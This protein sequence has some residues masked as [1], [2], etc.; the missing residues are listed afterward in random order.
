MFWKPRG[1]IGDP[2]IVIII[3]LVCFLLDFL[4]VINWS[5]DHQSNIGFIAFLVFGKEKQKSFVLQI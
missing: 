2:T 5:Y 4:N 3:I 1:K